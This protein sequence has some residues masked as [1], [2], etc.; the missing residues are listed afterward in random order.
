MKFQ[1]L[2]KA[3]YIPEAQ[4]FVCVICLYILNEKAHNEMNKGMLKFTSDYKS[5][6]NYL[7]GQWIAE[8]KENIIQPFINNDDDDDDDDDDGDDDKTMKIGNGGWSLKNTSR[9]EPIFQTLCR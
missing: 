3:T 7:V 6:V 8:L 5:P 9:N 4:Q 1:H 2:F